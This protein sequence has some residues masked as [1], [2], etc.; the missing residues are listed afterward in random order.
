[1]AVREIEKRTNKARLV[2]SQAAEWLSLNAS[3]CHFF[4]S[5]IFGFAHLQLAIVASDT[6]LE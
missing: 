1:L 5:I 2:Q 4:I 6:L 3:G